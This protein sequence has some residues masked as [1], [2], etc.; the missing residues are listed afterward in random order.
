M[1]EYKIGD[2]VILTDKLPNHWNE[3]MQHYLS[4][5]VEIAWKNS[6]HF[7]FL[8][9]NSWS[10]KVSDIINYATEESIEKARINRKKEEKKLV[11]LLKSY[12]YRAEDVANIATCVFG[13]EFVN[14]KAVDK[15][16]F[17][18]FIYFPE[19]LI[20]NSKKQK[21]T[22]KDLYVQFKVVIRPEKFKH[23]NDYKAQIDFLGRRRTLSLKEFESG[24]RHS[25]LRSHRNEYGDFCLG[26]SDYSLIIQELQISLSENSWNMLFLSLEN[27]LKW[28]SL[29]GGPHI[30]LENITYSAKSNN[31]LLD[32]YAE[33]ILPLI[34]VSC[35]EYQE[36]SIK[37]IPGHSEL[38]NVINVNSP[39]RNLRSYSK[40]E[41]E[42]KIEDANKSLEKITIEWDKNVTPMRVIDEEIEKSD[43][44]WD[45]VQAYADIIT[46][47]GSI[48]I[49]QLNYERAKN[50][51]KERVFRKV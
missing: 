12:V 43:L 45:V 24:Y 39:I 35:L 5:V 40:E 31:K 37:V 50:R 6:T 3:M 13:K 16:N 18:I 29:E 44:T 15:N 23:K 41:I 36:D 25:H 14:I 38:F 34:P 32:N 33:T 9:D 17:S 47:K 19:L 48:Y 30:K 11:E 51:N 22:I 2:T 49:K 4:N 21:H 10:F 20:N 8:G 42:K 28:E 1:N 27:Y 26:N 7:G 46:K